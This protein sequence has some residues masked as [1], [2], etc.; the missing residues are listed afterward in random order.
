MKYWLEVLFGA[1]T[2]GLG[3]LY[4]GLSKRVR[5]S[6]AREQAIAEGIKY[7]LMFQLRELGERY[8]KAG[9]CSTEEKHEYEK[10]YRCYN[11]LNGNGTIR[12]LKDQVLRL[13]P[14]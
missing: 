4:A 11:A 5:E 12:E 6:R 13:P 1:V 8:V 7:L 10:V 3:G 2:A 14:A 9:R